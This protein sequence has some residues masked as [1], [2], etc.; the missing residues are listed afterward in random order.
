MKRIF[1]SQRPVGL[2][3]ILIFILSF[4]GSSA[5]AAEDAPCVKVLFSPQ[6]NCARE[7]VSEIDSAKKQVWAAL[8]FFTSRPLAQALVRAKERGLD[9]RVCTDVEQPTYEYSKIKFLENKG[10]SIR[11][12]GAAG[13]M[14]N[15]FC[16]IDNHIV[17]T[18]SYNWT[19][20]A[21]LKNDENLLIIRSE[22]IARIFRK[23]F[24]NL[25][26]GQ[27]VD[28]YE[29]KDKTRM[30][31]VPETGFITVIPLIAK[32]GAGAAY[33]ANKNSKKFHRPDCRWAVKIKPE[34]RI[35]FSTKQEAIDKGY[36]PCKV[37][38]P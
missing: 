3:L 35:D 37:C 7:I 28:A 20:S 24:E 4:I 27:K 9:V 14:H 22:D 19:N 31:K 17:I 16:L 26:N 11:L 23:E 6:D 15:K 34:N 10:I 25:W 5:A 12:V 36:A 1:S 29:Y 13:I 2:C 33:I 18:G 8:Y 30:E 38:K 21:D 32:S